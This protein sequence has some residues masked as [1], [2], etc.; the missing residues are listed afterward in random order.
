[1]YYSV[2]GCQLSVYADDHQLYTSNI[3]AKEDESILNTQARLTSHW[4]MENSL[5]AN[6][7]KFQTMVLNAKKKESTPIT[8]TLDDTA[9]IEPTN[10]M[11]LL[12]IIID[13][14]LNFSEHVKTIAVQVRRLVGVIMRLRNLIPEKAKLQRYRMAILPHLTYC[15]VVWHFLKASD[16]RKLE[17]IQEKALRAIYCDRVSSYEELLAAAGLP[18]LF[19]RRLQGIAI[20]MF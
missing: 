15:S 17:R 6:K 8:I 12:G 2:S 19:D 7:D 11:K 20:L 18:T 3:D 4:Y 5:L 9:P 16:T 1:M 13:D 14:K 10:L